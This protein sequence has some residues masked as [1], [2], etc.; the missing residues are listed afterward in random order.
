[1]CTLVECHEVSKAPHP[2]FLIFYLAQH[3]ML[4]WVKGLG[5]IKKALYVGEPVKSF[6]RVWTLSCAFYW[7]V[8]VAKRL[9][10][11]TWKTGSRVRIPLEARFFPNLNGASLHRAFTLI[12]PSPHMLIV[13]RHNLLRSD[14]CRSKGPQTS[15][16]CFLKRKWLQ[17]RD[18]KYITVFYYERL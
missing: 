5:P 4:V 1:M 13:E 2:H 3:F 14:G 11:P 12:L 8:R 16:Q 10:I 17:T 18:S 7:G 15:I 9:V 6:L